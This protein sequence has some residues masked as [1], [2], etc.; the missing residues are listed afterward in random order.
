MKEGK[1]FQYLEDLLKD[2]EE[3]LK[4]EENKRAEK[5]A[6]IEKESDL[7]PSA[8]ETKEPEEPEGEEPKKKNAHRRRRSAGLAMTRMKTALISLVAVGIIIGA[9]FGASALIDQANSSFINGASIFYPIASDSVISLN[10]YPEG[11]A[12]TTGNTVEYV[13]HTGKLIAKNSH[14]YNSPVAKSAGKHLLLYD[15]GGKEL[16]IE[17]NARVDTVVKT[18]AEVANGAVAPNGNFAYVLNADGSYQTHV[19]V[20][21]AN[22]KLLFEWGGPDYLLDVSLSDNGKKIAFS[23]ISVKN[24]SYTTTV[25]VFDIASSDKKQLAACTF[26][27]E[28]AFTVRFISNKEV[29]VQTDSGVYLIDSQ[30]TLNQITAFS[31]N[32]LKH[33]T[34]PSDGLSCVALNLFGNEKNTELRFFNKRLDHIFTKNFD[35]SV[36]GMSADRHC[37]ALRFQDRV[38]VFDANETEI[39]SFQLH[40]SSYRLLVNDE[41]IYLLTANGLK[42]YETD[43]H[44]AEDQTPEVDS[45]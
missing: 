13:D 10:P 44:S 14:L 34:P 17:K 19:F 8:G 5:I 38:C 36:Y 40:E 2:P 25:Y 24:A 1:D 33:T 15:K 12:I 3:I 39:G 29:G 30:G 9:I 6:A 45:E 18:D 26:E 42:C 32:E 11:I 4:D 37:T 43:Y 31:P 7:M 23:M 22:D 16:R 28:A 21:S 41:R 27:R 35:E 20:R